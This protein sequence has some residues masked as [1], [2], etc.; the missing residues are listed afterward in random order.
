MVESAVPTGRAQMFSTLLLQAQNAMPQAERL[1]W[2]LK[3][4]EWLTIFAILIGPIIA[5]LTQLAIQKRQRVRDQKLWVYST[6]MSYR[7]TWAAADFVRAIN[8]VDVV[9]FDYKAIRDKRK[10]IM[11]H[12]K[13]TTKPDGTLEPVDWNRA[14][15][16]FAELL[17]LMGKQLGYAFEHTQIKQT[18]YYPVAHEKL[19]RTAIELREKGLAVLEGRTAIKVKMDGQPEV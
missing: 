2:G 5:V 16:L 10:A 11:D 7:A 1:H 4:V 15:D 3:I 8:F 19:D 9:F 17:D 13:A 6:L 18:A 12:I 14:E